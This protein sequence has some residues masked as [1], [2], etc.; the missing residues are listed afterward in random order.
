MEVLLGIC[1]FDPE[2]DSSP[3]IREYTVTVDGHQTVLDA[4][5]LAW[6]QDPT[7]SFR[8]SCRSAICG[9]C[10]MRINGKPALA[11]QTLVAAAIEN[12]KRI[13]LEPLPHFRQL[14]DLVV[15]FDPFFESLKSAVPWLLLRKDYS[16]LMEP[17]IA[18][19]LEDPA[20]CILC[21][22]CGGAEDAAGDVKP[23]GL[24]KTLRFSGDPRDALGVERF[25][26]LGVPLD[27]VKL[28]VKNLPERC[29]KGI[30]I[31]EDSFPNGGGD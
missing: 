22:I 4:L 12:G 24:I 23:A 30:R 1:R 10:A 19:R 11:C 16:G 9:S 15:D 18:R 6:Q 20:T 28:F 26:L 29:P 13:V 31:W 5:I 7:L 17:D 3:F 27:I 14:K 2:K 25:K 8:R 21:G